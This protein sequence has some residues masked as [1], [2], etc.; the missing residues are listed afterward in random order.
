[1]RKLRKF[2]LR[3]PVI[4]RVVAFFYRLFIGLRVVIY[5]FKWLIIWLFKSRETTNFTYDL[6]SINRRYLISLIADILGKSCNEIEGYV[7]EIENDNDLKSH[8]SA[9]VAE[10]RSKINVDSEIKFGRRIGWYAFARATKPKIIVET[11]VDKG[12]GSCVLTAALMRNAQEGNPGYYYGTDIN[13][14]AGFFLAGNYAKFGKILYGDSIS[15]LQAL[16]QKID[17]FIN[18]SDHSADYEKKEY[19]TISQKLSS[20]AIILGDNSHVTDKLLDFATETQRQFI[21]FSEMPAR[22]WYPGAGIG[23][24]FRRTAID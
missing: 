23:I 11:G 24:A 20:A 9:R 15:T 17:L 8:V 6:G 12:L 7:N 3:L 18:D 19:D 5:P 1:M 4:N 22:H 16:E 13:P 14:D 10:F 2:I 21:F